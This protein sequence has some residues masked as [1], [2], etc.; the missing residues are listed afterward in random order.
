MESRPNGERF[1]CTASDSYLDLI[2][3]SDAHLD[4]IR[5]PYVLYGVK[6]IDLVSLW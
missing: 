2:R 1:A 3:A 6:H 4:L 5:A